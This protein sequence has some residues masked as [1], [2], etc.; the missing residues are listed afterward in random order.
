[1]TPQDNVVR[2]GMVHKAGIRPGLRDAAAE[3]P[4]LSLRLLV[5]SP[6]ARISR[7]RFGLYGLRAWRHFGS[8][9]RLR[10]HDGLPEQTPCVRGRPAPVYMHRHLRWIH[11][12]GYPL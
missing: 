8:W 1:S 9:V 2:Y 4:L 6:S 10:T 5:H 3:V 7:Q 11:D 12:G